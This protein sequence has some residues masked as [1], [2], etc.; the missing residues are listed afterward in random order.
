M[1]LALELSIQPAL[2]V[3]LLLSR[4]WVFVALHLV[5]L[6]SNVRRFL[7]EGVTVFET[8]AFVRLGKERGLAFQ[9]FVFYLF[10]TLGIMVAVIMVGIIELAP[11]KASRGVPPAARVVSPGVT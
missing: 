2:I 6:Y 10:G 4:R 9:K 8:D 3:V 11:T 5:P 7:D 1:L